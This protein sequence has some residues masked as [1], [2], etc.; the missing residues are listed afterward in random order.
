M[1]LN[2][3]AHEHSA[4]HEISWSRLGVLLIELTEIIARSWQPEIVVGIAKGGVIPAIFLSSALRLD[5]LP[6]KLSSR[7][8]EKVVLSTPQWF[9]Y[10]TEHVKNKRVLLV[11][12]I[13]IAGRTLSMAMNELK[14]C[15]AQ[16][17]RTATLA[18]HRGSIRPDFVVLETDALI[19]WPWD[20]DVHDAQGQWAINPEYQAELNKI[21]GYHP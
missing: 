12:D 2:P 10:P 8:N 13:A 19:V 18:I 15:G 7:H 16:E 1:T 17:V 6:I 4:A 14:Q 11:D 9:V 5:F 3:Y 20:R 21:A